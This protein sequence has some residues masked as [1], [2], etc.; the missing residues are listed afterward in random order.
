M[1]N[2]YK[3]HLVTLLFFTDCCILTFTFYF[4]LSP[5][6][7]CLFKKKNKINHITMK[8]GNIFIQA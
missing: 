1:S 6:K 4:V 5:I 8:S 7:F 2:D 3:I